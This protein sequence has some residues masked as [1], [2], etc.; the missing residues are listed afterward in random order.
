MAHSL[1][2][3]PNEILLRILEML[4]CRDI[5]ACHATCSRMRVL[6]TD[7]IALQYSIELSACGMIDGRQDPHTLP[8]QERLDRIRRYTAAWET[9]LWTSRLALPHLVGLESPI[10][11]SG[12]VFLLP[13]SVVGAIADSVTGVQVQQIPSEL[14]A[15]KEDH[16][17]HSIPVL[18]LTGNGKIRLDAAQEL[19]V[20]RERNFI[21]GQTVTRTHVHSLL[22]GE[23]HPLAF[24]HGVMETMDPGLA[25]EDMCGDLLLEAIA[26]DVGGICTPIVRNWK[27]GLVEAK[28]TVMIKHR[29]MAFLDKQ[30]II[31]VTGGTYLALYPTCLQVTS[32]VSVDTTPTL[33]E[34]RSYSF[35]LPEFLQHKLLH[36]HTQ[37]SNLEHIPPPH[38]CFYP[39]PADR[40]ISVAIN[41]SGKRF[42]IDIP[43]RTFKTYISSHPGGAAA[44]I[45][46]DA[47]GTHGARMV[48]VSPFDTGRWTLSGSRRMTFRRALEPDG[49]N[50]L[51]LLDYSPRRVARAVARGTA[52]VLHGAEVGT[53]Y[54]GPECGPLR[55]LL[56]CIV[57]EVPL[58]D[59]MGEW[60]EGVES[61]WLCENGV[62]FLKCDAV[63]HRILDAC[64]YTI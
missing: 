7:S 61:A 44:I 42:V 4:G 23:A 1:P 22:T 2:F 32:L 51:T 36:I 25:F 45:P 52:T 14:R 10:S 3:L 60:G 16:Q 47:W 19:I 33:A 35:A 54:T 59:I 57:T 48:H 28:G 5:L 49:P 18:A 62:L 8:I 6:I 21:G 20:F 55:T 24:A 63:S 29:Y 30:H 58:P 50:M 9:L 31:S 37:I 64:A 27:T 40:L 26:S 13:P 43:V 17:I 15:I 53:V 39:D 56:P 34:S 38:G 41:S 12:D 46:W 11:V